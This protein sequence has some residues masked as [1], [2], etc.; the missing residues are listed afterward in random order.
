LDYSSNAIS[1]EIP[2]LHP[3][4][5]SAPR[6]PDT[7][8]NDLSDG[9]EFDAKP[10]KLDYSKNTVSKEV[11]NNHPS[12]SGSSKTY[13]SQMAKAAIDYGLD[14]ATAFS[15][16]PSPSGGSVGTPDTS[17]DTSK[18]WSTKPGKAGSKA[19]G[20]GGSAAAKAANYPDAKGGSVPMEMTDPARTRDNKAPRAMDHAEDL[21]TPSAM[22]PDGTFNLVK[23][24]DVQIA[25]DH[26]KNAEQAQPYKAKYAE[27]KRHIARRAQD[28]GVSH[29]VPQ[30]W[31]LM[32]A[33][34]ADAISSQ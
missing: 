17:G 30:D 34:H 25:V 21:T 11:P 28:L 32:L 31:Q 2:D 4:G 14:T 20:I 29:L 26:V 18:A 15:K 13:A 19:S 10:S 27:V 33:L 6:T 8:A 16:A 22:L 12:G 23:K 1:K 7:N 5:L 3:P 24:Q 9:T